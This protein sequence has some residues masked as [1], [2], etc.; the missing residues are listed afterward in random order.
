MGNRSIL[1]RREMARGDVLLTIPALRGLK[2][3]YPNC[4]IT[5]LSKEPYEETIKGHP[6]IDKIVTNEDKADEN[7]YDLFFDFDLAYEK[8]FKIHIIDAYC[9][10]ANVEP[11]HKRT[12]IALNQQQRSFSKNY[13]AKNDFASEKILIGL[14]SGGVSWPCKLWGK[15]NF[16]YVLEFF[17]ENL[18]VRIIEL[19]ASDCQA[20]GLD[21]NLIGK[22][23]VKETA[24]ILEE[25]DLLLCID[26]LPLH[27]AG[28]VNTPVVAVFG[29]TDP[30][31]ILPFN[32][33]SLGIQ[34]DGEC[35]G[36]RHWPLFPKTEAKCIKNRIYCLEEVS[37]EEVIEGVWNMLLKTSKLENMICD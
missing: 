13:L 30:D 19:G 23:T 27:L 6:L 3:K 31:K 26:S 34:S 4:R 21:M 37:R 10:V 1:V 35:T 5:F 16:K 12:S 36:C 24:A 15:E 33:I 11:S 14:H 2:E 29:C 8:N 20:I 32:D 18:E 9:Q 25:C 28:A 22:T 17:K 7:D